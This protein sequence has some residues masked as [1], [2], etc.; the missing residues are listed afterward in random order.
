[1][2]KSYSLKERIQIGGRK[3]E[4]EFSEAMNIK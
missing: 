1:M 4:E 2:V 3:I